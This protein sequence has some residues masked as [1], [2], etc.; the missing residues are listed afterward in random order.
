MPP[1]NDSAYDEPDL[2][3]EEKR[4]LAE[5]DGPTPTPTPTP[6]AT[7]EGD[8]T[9]V[10]T[11]P[12]PAPAPTPTPAPAPAPSEDDEFKEFLGKHQGKSPEELA[13]IAFDQNKRAAREGFNARQTQQRFDVLESNAKK[14]LESRTQSIAQRREEFAKRLREDPDQATQ[15]LHERLLTD[16][17][18]RAEAEYVSNQQSAAIELA[19]TAL[20]HLRETKDDVYAFGLEMNYGPE[21]LDA[22]VDGRDLVV[23]TMAKQFADLFKAGLVDITGKL[24]V[25]APN[26]VEQTDPRLKPQPAQVQTLSSAPG[27]TPATERSIADQIADLTRMPDDEFAKLDPKLIDSLLN[28]A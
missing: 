4:I 9:K 26:P 16:E 25:Q 17:E 1:A 11:A 21:N 10:D 6:A 3:D 12:A 14:L 28:A 19:T 8:K 13:R 24:L 15:E 18:Q 22:I 20:P 7:E 5:L 23:L 27:R 2:T